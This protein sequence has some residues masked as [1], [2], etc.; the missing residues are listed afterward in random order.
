M[1]VIFY[2]PEKIISIRFYTTYKNCFTI[3]FCLYNKTYT[4]FKQNYYDT[5]SFY[6]EYKT[7]N[8]DNNLSFK[9][10]D[11]IYLSRL[12][13]IKNNNRKYRNFIKIPST[14]YNTIYAFFI[15]NKYYTIY[16]NIKYYNKLYTI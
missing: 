10:F 2:I 6:Y 15:Y 7:H 5:V 13:I 14:F 12:D 1:S 3:K 9:I 11:N 16:D 4:S 8:V